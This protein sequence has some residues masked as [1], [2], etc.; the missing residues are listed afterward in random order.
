MKKDK[1]S[2]SKIFISYSSKDA[3]YAELL[4]SLLGEKGFE[5]WLNTT[6]IKAGASWE[7]TI[8]K[9][10]DESKFV[11]ALLSSDYLDSA[12]SLVE[13]G[14][15]YGSG[16]KIIPILLSGQLSDLPLRLAGL[17]VQMIDAQKM[18]KNSLLNLIEQQTT[19]EAA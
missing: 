11:I 12:F 6:N 9:A 8:S 10:L 17:K 1:D 19:A 15:A 14:A 16:K 3:A 4:A 18:D 2:K 7:N 5:I 13:L